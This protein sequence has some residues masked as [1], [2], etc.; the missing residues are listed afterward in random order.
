MYVFLFF[1]TTSLVNINLYLILFIQILNIM[2]NSQS[3]IRD[4]ELMTIVT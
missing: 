3:P 4:K 1:A 2:R